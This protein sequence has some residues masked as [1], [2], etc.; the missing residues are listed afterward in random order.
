MGV[1]VIPDALRKSD[2]FRDLS[3][4]DMALLAEQATLRELPRGSILYMKGEQSN[5]TFCAISSGAVNVVAKDG[6]IVRELGPGEVVGEIALSDTRHVRTVT[7]IT[8]DPTTCL[9]W[10][11]Q[12]VKA[13]VPGLWKKLLQ[14]AWKHIQDYYED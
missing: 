12:D 2:V 10:N 14:L 6:H 7:V 11:I 1:S 3:D 13:S 8:K 4:N 9:E 5:N